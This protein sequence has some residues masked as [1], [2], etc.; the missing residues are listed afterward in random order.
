MF[1]HILNAVVDN[2]LPYTVTSSATTACYIIVVVLDCQEA[3]LANPI[4]FDVLA[5]L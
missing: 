2:S 4:H 3:V 1:A 5:I